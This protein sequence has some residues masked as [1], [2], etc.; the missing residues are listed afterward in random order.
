MWDSYAIFSHENFLTSGRGVIAPNLPESAANLDELEVMYI[1]YDYRRA[2]RK[3]ML[4][5]YFAIMTLSK[6]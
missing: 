3:R 5:R 6:R 1:V 2:D 4:R